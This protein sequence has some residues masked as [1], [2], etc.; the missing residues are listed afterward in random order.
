[1]NQIQNEEPMGNSV[2]EQ[3]SQSEEQALSWAEQKQLERREY[4]ERK[5]A[6]L[7]EASDS[8]YGRARE[9]SSFVPF[10]QPI[11]VDH[12]SAPGHRRHLARIDSSYRKSF[13]LSNQAQQALVQLEGVGKG[14]IS[15]DDPD[16][17]VK[18]RAQLDVLE[19]KQ[20]LMKTA[21]GA[22]RKLKGPEEKVAALVALGLT[23]EQASKLIIP[24]HGRDGGYPP[25]ELTN[26]NSNIRRIRGRIEDLEKARQFQDAEHQ[27]VGYTCRED[28]AENRVMFFFD[29]KPEKDVR[30]LLKSVSF[31]WAPN[32]GAWIRQLSLDG[33]AAANY[34]REMLDQAS[35]TD[36]G[37]G[38]V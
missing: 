37:A 11:L 12:Y 10:G 7:S 5:A 32:R 1:M 28:I 30:S 19:A 31:K 21:N 22:I 29:S 14:G 6:G 36:I 15:S 2:D 17:I 20:S 9:M 16:A 26:N 24:K 8:A 34:V 23:D 4:L 13:E 33:R 3:D 18:L 35:S 38:L 25:Y 27:G